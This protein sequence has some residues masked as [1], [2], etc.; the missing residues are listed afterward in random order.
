MAIYIRCTKCKCDHK[1]GVKICRKC[2]S[3]IAK[4]KKYKVVVKTPKGNRMVRLVD[5][6]T[7]AKRVESSLKGQ[8]AE[9]RLLGITKAP[10]VSEIWD[11][12]IIWAKK[13]KKSWRDD[14]GRWRKHVEQQVEGKRMNQLA[15]HDIEKILT[16]MVKNAEDK[17]KKHAP[18][19]VKHVLVLIK[20]VYNWAND[21]DL[22]DGPNPA[23]RIKPPKVQN[24][25]TECLTEPELGRLL[26]VLNSWRNQ[27][28]ALVVKFSLYTGFRQDEVMGLKWKHVD[29][30]KAFIKLIDPKGNPTTLPLG[31]EALSILRQAKALLPYADCPYVFPNNKGDRRVSFYKIWSRIRNAAGLSKNFRFHGLRHTFA[32]Y[33][34]SSGEVDLYTLQKLLNHQNPQMT[35][36]YAHLLDRTLRNGANVA[37]KVFGDGKS[38]DSDPHISIDSI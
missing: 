17:D 8:I 33:L 22:F 24:E 2:E 25:V 7:L 1:I 5:T 19:T 20:R 18:A 13:H 4:N 36:R 11:Q 29:M 16:G 34:A 10:F 28:G 27:L 3:P 32:S 38:K 35:Q 37:D 30:D 12:Y 21:Q 6:L 9:Q 23:A 31:G 26:E 14:L 15:G